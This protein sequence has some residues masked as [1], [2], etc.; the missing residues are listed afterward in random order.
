MA[1]NVLVMSAG[2]TPGIAVIQALKQQDEIPVR[3]VAADMN[4][5]SVGF[6]LS[7]G[8]AIVP[9]ASAP[10]FIGRVLDLC[11]AEGIRVVFPILDE[12][13]Q[14]F[15]D[16]QGDFLAAGVTVVTNAPHVVRVA[17]DKYETYRFCDAH[18]IRAPA[19]F[20]PH[21]RDRMLGARFPLIVKPRAGRGSAGVFKAHDV[22]QLDFFCGYVADPLVQECITGTE[23]TIDILTTFEGDTLGV[24]PRERIQTKAGMSVKGRTVKDRRLIEYGRRVAQTV[25]LFPRGNVQC[26][27]DGKD[28]Y[29]IE[30]NPKFAA[31]LPLTVRAG[32]NMPLLLVKMCL[33]EPVRREI[34]DWEDDLTMLRYWQEIYIPGGQQGEAPKT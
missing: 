30:I 14:G 16:H 12:E 15:A 3:V 1:L 5:L 29:L 4:P 2:A 19:S 10:D 6:R 26:M 7:D 27:D 31:T 20:L 9:G 13:L 18:D 28:L 25:G 11:A 22:Q 32:V 21:E 17:K 8:Q 33:G 24:V 34:D 23:Y